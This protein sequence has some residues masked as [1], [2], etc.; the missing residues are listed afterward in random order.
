MVLRDS[1]LLSSALLNDIYR[2]K[3]ED[4]GFYGGGHKGES[5]N[6]GAKG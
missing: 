6:E 3:D 5:K 2:R 4:K 1:E